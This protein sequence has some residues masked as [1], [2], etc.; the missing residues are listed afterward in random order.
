M[1]RFLKSALSNNDNDTSSS[2]NALESSIKSEIEKISV[3]KR[4][5][6]KNNVYTPELRYKIGKHAAEYGNIHAVAKYSKDLGIHVPESSVR[7]MK[8]QYL[9]L[10]KKDT[11]QQQKHLPLKKKGQPLRLGHTLDNLVQR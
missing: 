11:S 9:E 4:T 1:W 5:Q 3:R 7:N 2:S 10:I 8:K 6:A